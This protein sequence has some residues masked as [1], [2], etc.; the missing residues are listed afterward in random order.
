[1]AANYLSAEL[2]SGSL[3]LNG[4][5]AYSMDVSLSSGDISGFAAGLS[6]EMETSSGKIDISASAEQLELEASSGD[7]QLTLAGAYLNYVSASTT[8]GNVT[9]ILPPVRNW[10]FGLDFD[11]ASGI[12]DKGTFPLVRSNGMYHSGDFDEFMIVAETSSGNLYLRS[13]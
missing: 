1:M 6:L 8:S 10:N 5:A 7:V 13:S 12:L 4:V 3:I 9:L 11:S 2:T